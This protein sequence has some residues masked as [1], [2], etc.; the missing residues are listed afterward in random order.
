M[1]HLWSFREFDYF[2]R[3]MYGLY[4]W[5]YLPNIE[6][7]KTLGGDGMLVI[8]LGILG[9]PLV[10][11]SLFGLGIALVLKKHWVKKKRESASDSSEEDEGYG[12]FQDS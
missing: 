8:C 7:L 9:L 4:Y 3:R 1:Y 10:I 6:L 5:A 12:F 2:G 11:A